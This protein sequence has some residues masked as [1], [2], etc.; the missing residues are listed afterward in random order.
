MLDGHTDRTDDKVAIGG[1]GFGV[2]AMLVAVERGWI[3]RDAALTRLRRMLDALLRATRYHGAFPHFLD[4]ASGVTIPMTPMDDAADLVE[5][6]FLVM[7]LLCARQYFNEDT[8]A[9]R[10]LRGDVDALYRDVEWDWFTRGGRDVLYWHWSPGNGWAMNHEIRGW[11]ECL[12]TYLLAVAAPR[13]AIAPQV[14][15]RGFAAGPG[16]VNG[17]SYYG[18]ELPLGMPYGGS[19]FFTHY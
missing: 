3:T 13:H 7:G 17:R 8:A 9:A 19:L 10:R 16:F 4:G 6:S 2:M 11:N 12:V 15:H 18:I 14:Y 5:T 1:S